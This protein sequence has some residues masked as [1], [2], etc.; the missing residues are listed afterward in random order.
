MTENEMVEQH[1]GFNG[2]EFEQIPRDSQGQGGLECCSPWS[3]KE[4]NMTQRQNNN[5]RGRAEK[6]N[7][8]LNPG[9]DPHLRNRRKGEPMKEMEEGWATKQ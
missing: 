7:R 3:Q 2:H 4:L 1:Y 6:R 8:D 5:K 9:E